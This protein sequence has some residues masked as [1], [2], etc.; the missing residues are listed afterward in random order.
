MCQINSLF[1]SLFHKMAFIHFIMHL[2]YILLVQSIW[3]TFTN[4]QL[5]RFDFD[6]SQKLTPT[7]IENSRDGQIV[8]NMSSVKNTDFLIGT[9]VRCP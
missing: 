2:C 9:L 5:S 8:F 4:W 6:G 3:L 7:F 1:S